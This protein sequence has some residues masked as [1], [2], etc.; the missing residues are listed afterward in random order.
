MGDDEVAAENKRLHATTMYPFERIGSQTHAFIGYV[1]DLRLGKDETMNSTIELDYVVEKAEFILN[2]RQDN[3]LQEVVNE[4]KELFRK[5]NPAQT[6]IDNLIDKL[7]TILN[8]S[9]YAKVGARGLGEPLESP[10]DLGCERLPGLNGDDLSQNAQ[11][12]GDG[13]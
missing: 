6:E 11:Q 13:T 5:Y 2:E 7:N 4:A 10:R 12:W 1:D 3:K 8:E 9:K